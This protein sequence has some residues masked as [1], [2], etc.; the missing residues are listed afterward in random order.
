MELSDEIERAEEALGYEL[1]DFQRGMLETLMT[2]GF[3]MGG[4]SSGKMAVKEVG[5]EIIRQRSLRGPHYTAVI[6]DEAGGF[7]DG[8]LWI[9]EKEE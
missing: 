8:V 7:G 5:Q 4:Q 2:G 3:I 9:S 1:L 6:M